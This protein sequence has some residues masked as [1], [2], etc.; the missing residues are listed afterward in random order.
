MAVARQQPMRLAAVADLTWPLELWRPD[1]PAAATIS[2]GRRV[3][4]R[5]RHRLRLPRWCPVAVVPGPSLSAGVIP[6]WLGG[7]AAQLLA[8]AGLAQG[9]VIAPYRAAALRAGADLMI[10]AELAAATA[11]PEAQLAVGA[12]IAALMPRDPGRTESV[13]GRANSVPTAPRLDMVSEDA[14]VGWA[15]QRLP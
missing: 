1:P 14:A 15:V 2:V 4:V 11:G 13:V 12:A 7:R 5:A 6:E 9:W 8:R 3:L 10:A